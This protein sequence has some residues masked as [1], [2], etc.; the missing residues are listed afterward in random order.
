MIRLALRLSA[1]LYA[2]LVLPLAFWL[3]A[4]ISGTVSPTSAFWGLPSR[5]PLPCLRWRRIQPNEVIIGETLA[6]KR[7]T[8]ASEAA[9][10]VSL[11]VIEP[12]YLFV[13][14]AEE[15]EWLDAYIGALDCSLQEAPK[16]LN[17]VCVN[18]AIDIPLGMVNNAMIVIGLEVSVRQE[19]VRKYLCPRSNIPSHFRTKDVA[20]SAANDSSPNCALPVRAVPLQEAQNGGLSDCPSP[21]NFIDA[22]VLMH[23]A[24]QPADK[25]FIHFNWAADLAKVVRLHSEPYAV[26]HE[27]C[28]FLSDTERAVDFIGTYAILGVGDHPNSCEP[29]IQANG[30]ILKYSSYL[31]RELPLGMLFLALPQSAS[32]DEPNI[33]S[34]TSRASNNTVWPSELGGEVKAYIGIGEITD[35]FY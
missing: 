8:N 17:A 19:G 26:E 3:G 29:F 5:F 10:I 20:A 35:G 34:A 21:L 33:L 30:A 31:D 23:E 13:Q 4:Q 12:E 9:S 15:M 18:L 27:P 32:R 14:V 24:G 28:G 11:S 7:V 2:P 1:S 6:S 25:G 22:L 16:V